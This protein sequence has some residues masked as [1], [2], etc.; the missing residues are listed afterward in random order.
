[1][2]WRLRDILYICDVKFTI[3]FNFPIRTKQKLDKDLSRKMNHEEVALKDRQ[4]G[5]GQIGR[6][7]V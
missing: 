4:F 6:A 1:M 5:K 7:H 3:I 2:F